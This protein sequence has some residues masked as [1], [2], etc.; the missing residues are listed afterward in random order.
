M[1]G[2]GKKK[3]QQNNMNS[4]R[5][6]RWQYMIIHYGWHTTLPLHRLHETHVPGFLIFT[7]IWGILRSILFFLPLLFSILHLFFSFKSMGEFG[8]AAF[9]LWPPTLVQSG[10]SIGDHFTRKARESDPMPQ[11]GLALRWIGAVEV[12]QRK[13]RQPTAPFKGTLKNCICRERNS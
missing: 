13:T 8:V 9:R 4:N 12:K 1:L 3:N 2:W 7:V 11:P 5:K 6:H 10:V